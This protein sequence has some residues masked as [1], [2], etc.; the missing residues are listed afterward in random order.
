MTPPGRTVPT[1]VQVCHSPRSQHLL[2][3]VVGGEHTPSHTHKLPHPS[4][5]FWPAF[6]YL[7]FQRP[8]LWSTPVREQA[9][10]G[11]LPLTPLQLPQHRLDSWCVPPPPP[12]YPRYTFASFANLSS[13]SLA[14]EYSPNYN[15]EFNFTA[16]SNNTCYTNVTDDQRRSACGADP[17]CYIRCV[18]WT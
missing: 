4:M 16:G 8:S 15:S 6:F 7:G 10:R 12:P 18:C 5:F 2:L 3:V 14:A 13:A 17:N 1:G 9:G 11:E